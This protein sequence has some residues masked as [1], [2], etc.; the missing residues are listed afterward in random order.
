MHTRLSVQ[1][2]VQSAVFWPLSGSE[3]PI[4]GDIQAGNLS[5]TRPGWDLLCLAFWRFLVSLSWEDQCALTQLWEA[6]MIPFLLFFFLFFLPT[7][8]TFRLCFCSCSWLGC[9]A[10]TSPERPGLKALRV[11]QL[12]Y[13][14][15]TLGTH[16]VT[17]I[18]AQLWE[19]SRF[20]CFL[21]C[22]LSS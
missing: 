17:G 3:C 5:N 4:V 18:W 16:R 19:E 15:V 12:D 11:P 2:L 9:G 13:A 8:W 6:M 10:W 21:R 7:G 1:E 14:L 20:V 22:T